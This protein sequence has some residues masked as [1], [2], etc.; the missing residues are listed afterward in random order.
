M[1]YLPW[2]GLGLLLLGGLLYL[3]IVYFPSRV[4]DTGL[5]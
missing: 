3:K 1:K 5:H 4:S 2:I